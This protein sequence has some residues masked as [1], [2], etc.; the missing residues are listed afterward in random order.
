MRA[1]EVA[2]RGAA[3]TLDRLFWPGRGTCRRV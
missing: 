1:G 3:W 2:T